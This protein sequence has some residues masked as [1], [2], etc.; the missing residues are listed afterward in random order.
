MVGGRPGWFAKG[1]ALVTVR[2]RRWT[3]AAGVKRE[4]WYVDVKVLGKDGRTR[5]VQRVSPIQ[6]RRAAEKLEHDVREDLLN[7]ENGEATADVTVPQFAE[8]AERFMM[9]YAV[10]NN[11]PS[12]VS[13]KET[14]LRV[15]LLPEFGES[16]LDEI[17]P[18]EVEAYKAKKLQAKLARK[19]VNNH[20][21]VL[22]KILSTAVEWRILQSVPRIQWMR[23]PPP[24]F[25]FLTFDEADRLIAHAD[26]EWRAMI[27]VALR[28]GLRHGELRALRWQD[29]DLVAGR[30]VVRRAV[31]GDIISTPKNG[32][33]REIAL[34]KQ[35][36]TVLR[37]QP[38]RGEFVFSTPDK[39]MLKK[40]VTKWPLWNACRRAGLR[41]IGWHSLRHS[42]ASHLVM[43]GAPIKAVQELLGHSTIEMTM[44]YAHLSPDARREAVKLLDVEDSAVLVWRVA[45]GAVIRFPTWPRRRLGERPAAT[46]AW[47]WSERRSTSLGAGTASSPS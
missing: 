13:A 23:P 24:E 38:R 21:T 30:I 40:G 25:D 46:I 4:A 28:T 22:R 2:R 34:S 27:T 45:S 10:T 17:S 32:R 33:I 31:W 19:S 37:E 15:H 8:F 29:V 16:R 18:A 36:P 43:R 3:D 6:N 47:P 11:K 41:R 9:T 20:L 26:G 5:R 42:F 39:S 14:I 1:E 7:A 35:A 12:E 44:R